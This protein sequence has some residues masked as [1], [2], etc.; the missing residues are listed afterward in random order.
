MPGKLL[1]GGRPAV[2]VRGSD[3]A[4]RPRPAVARAHRSCRWCSR[5]GRA[6]SRSPRVLPS[7]SGA[8]ADLTSVQLA[9]A[10]P[11]QLAHEA[12]EQTLQLSGR[13]LA[14]YFEAP[15]PLRPRAPG[16]TFL[17]L[18]AAGLL[19][20]VPGSA[21][22]RPPAQ[23]SR[24]RGERTRSPRFS[25]ARPPASRSPTRTPSSSFRSRDLVAVRAGAH[26][27]D[28]QR[29][30]SGV[31]RPSTATSTS[32]T[33]ASATDFCA[34]TG[35]P[36]TSGQLSASGHLQEDRGDARA[37]RP[38][39]AGSHHP[40]LGVDYTRSLL[41]DQGAL[42]ILRSPSEVVHAARRSKLTVP[43]RG[44]DARRGSIRSPAAA[45]RSSST[46]CAISSRRRRSI[47]R[48]LGVMREAHRLGISTTATDVRARQTLSRQG[49]ALPADP[50]AAG[51]DAGGFQAFFSWTFRTTASSSW[52]GGRVAA[53]APDHLLTQAVLAVLPRQHAAHQLVVGGH[54]KKIGQVALGGA[55][56]L[57]SVMIEENVVSA[58][59]IRI[60]QR[61]RAP[62]S[63]SS[64]HSALNGGASAT[65]S[66]ALSRSGTSYP[67]TA[68]PTRRRTPASRS[69]EPPPGPVLH[70]R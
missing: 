27:D 20:T 53:R 21:S 23:Q 62:A 2:R 31:V 41:V 36:A 10:G 63:T 35:G 8:R 15:L 43:E 9:R 40:T 48:W 61:R 34:F 45:P 57:G 42:S 54:R 14:R 47:R 3:A 28:P 16:S 24:E 4:S 25:S 65:R 64:A 39:H 18:A 68:R 29:L 56:D 11:G 33:S 6:R 58:A 67:P 32:R 49:R 66:T 44:A 59:G 60:A 69:I 26:G 5:S 46:R 13:L 38:A 12:A 70:R 19:E 17:E 52:C 7:W 22:S 30:H 37:R 50:R 55:D 51:R 1:I